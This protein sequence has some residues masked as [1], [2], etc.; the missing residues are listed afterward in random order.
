[1]AIKQLEEGVTSG[2]KFL[3]WYNDPVQFYR[4]VFKEDPFDYQADILRLVKKGHKRILCCACGGSG[5]TKLLASI[6]LWYVTVKSRFEGRQEVIVI[7]GSARQAKNLYNYCKDALLDNPILNRLVEG[8]P[9]ISE[10]RFKDRSVIRALPSSLTAIQGQHGN[11]VLLDEAS[12]VDDFLIRDTYRIVGAHK[13]AIIM[14]STP[15]Y[16]NSLFVEMWE[17]TDK[18]PEWIRRSWDA[19]DCPLLDDDMIEEAKKLP[20]Q[21]FEIF[22]LGKPYPMTGTMLPLDKLKACTR[23]VKRFT[24]NVEYPTFMGVDWGWG[25]PL[26]IV[27]L[28]KKQDTYLIL[29]TFLKKGGTFEEIHDWIESRAKY[30][31]V[32]SIYCDA[33]DVGENQRLASRGLPVIPVAFNKEKG[34]L[35][36]KLKDLVIKTKIFIPEDEYDLI[37]QLRTYTWEKKENDD[38]VDALL[39]AIKESDVEPINNITFSVRRIK[40]SR[41]W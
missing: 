18:Y 34:Y 15:T 20:S 9:K 7:S 21:T 36:S 29:E 17:N 41:R 8:E 27:I 10:T 12:L 40:K 33:S 25:H 31:K 5:K 28:Q 30:Y 39:L 32:R 35:Q 19:Y 23:G 38:L 14:S 11:L 4:D 13:G 3:E 37:N 2:L 16:Y 24:F 6:G 22:W 1:M 26:G